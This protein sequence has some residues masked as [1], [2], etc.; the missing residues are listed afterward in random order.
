MYSGYFVG[1]TSLFIA[2]LIAA[3]IIA[4]KIV[5]LGGVFLPAG[6]VVFPLSYIIGDVMT[7]IFGFQKAK[8]AIL[9][10]FVANFI[11]VLAIAAAQALP[12]APFWDLQLSFDAI[13]GVAPRIL[14]AS[15]SGYLGGSLLNAWSMH[16][17]KELT[18]GRF[19]WLRTISSTVLGEGVDTILFLGIAFGGL[20]ASAQI[21]TMVLTQWVVKVVYE[22]VATPLT[23]FVITKLKKAG[24]Q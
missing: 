10:G 15:F 4:V 5:G 17:I 2:C 20:L 7:E 6:I 11:V 14:V 19:L 22:V 23:Y 21:V 12:A 8:F 3:N 16:K 18:K 24:V 1:L 13:L 9:L